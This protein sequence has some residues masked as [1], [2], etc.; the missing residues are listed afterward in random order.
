[1]AEIVE[2]NLAQARC[3]EGALVAP[4]QLRRVERVPGL[5]VAERKVVVTAVRA[6]LLLALELC[7]QPVGHRHG[8]ARAA[9]LRRAELAAR[10]CTSAADHAGRPVDVAP[11]QCEQLALAQPGQR[12]G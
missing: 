6:A 8:S 7:G 4:A 10:V 3:D 1:V 5:R 2:A 11:A 9:R 12:R